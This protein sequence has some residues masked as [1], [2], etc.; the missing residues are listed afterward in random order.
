[1]GVAY[2]LQVLGQQRLEPTAAS[3]IMSL[4]SVVA[5]ITGWLILRESMTSVEL[6]GCCLVFAAVILSQ[7]PTKIMRH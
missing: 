6:L 1:M 3:L 2:S 4:E 5:A 7:I